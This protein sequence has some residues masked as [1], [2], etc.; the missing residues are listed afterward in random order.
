MFCVLVVSGTYG[1]LRRRALVRRAAEA[2]SFF[3][4]GAH[5]T[6]S[7]NRLLVV[8]P[9]L[10]RDDVVRRRAH[11]RRPPRARRGL[12][13]LEDARRSRGRGRRRRFH[14]GQFLELPPQ[15]RSYRCVVLT[16]TFQFAEQFLRQ[17]S[18]FGGIVPR[19]ALGA[20]R[21]CWRLGARRWRPAALLKGRE[22][23]AEPAAGGS[24]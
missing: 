16:E 15:G 5:R 8:G 17:A 7:S 2:C 12:E 22:A 18:S 19:V 21:P 6:S 11:G 10:A 1:R 23:R 14:A 13:V 20:P 24:S 4:T 9:A 3:P